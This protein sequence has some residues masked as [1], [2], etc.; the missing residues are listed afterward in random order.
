MQDATA[1][2]QDRYG[3]VVVG[4]MND[5]I[6]SRLPS[7]AHTGLAWYVHSHRIEQSYASAYPFDMHYVMCVCSEEQAPFIGQ[8]V[9]EGSTE[10][11]WRLDGVSGDRLVHLTTQLNWR[12]NEGK[13]H[14]QYMLGYTDAGEPTGLPQVCMIYAYIPQV[15]KHV[16]QIDCNVCLCCLTFS[17]SAS[18]SR[19]LTR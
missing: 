18:W 4:G 9:E 6:A 19:V 5:V 12:L 13:G 3:T 11:K 16:H 10:H 15:S 7:A 8:E 17:R 14:A 1:Y 2:P